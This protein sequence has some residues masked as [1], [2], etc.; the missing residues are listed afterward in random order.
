MA[1]RFPAYD[2]IQAVLSSEFLPTGKLPADLLAALLAHAPTRDPSLVVGP[3]IGVDCAVIQASGKLLVLKSDPITFATDEIGWYAVQINANDIATTGAEPRWF[4][5]TL[6]LPGSSTTQAL[7]EQIAGQLFAAC[8]AEG[9]TLAGG[10]TEITY[11][12]DRPILIGMLIGEVSPEQLVTPRGAQVG[13]KILLTKGVP[14]EATALLARERPEHLEGILT[15]QEIQ[16]ARDYLHHP[17]IS[18]TRE[19]RIALRSGRIH[20]MHDPTEGGLLTALWELAEASGLSVIVNLEA[21]PVPELSRKVCQAFGLDPFGAIASGALL[22]ACHPQDAGQVQLALANEGIV[23]AE[24]GSY[25]A[26]T[27]GESVAWQLIDGEKR[28]LPRPTR[29]EI[30]QVFE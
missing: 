14:I 11:G 18:V 8:E 27:E 3:G 5:A 23:C 25:I 4:M 20:A 29:D 30:A 28:H 9:I 7:V 6:L 1:Q 24:I 2:R 12:L 16:E 10:H 22:M 17:G 19:A 15:E 21:A 26:A 13:D